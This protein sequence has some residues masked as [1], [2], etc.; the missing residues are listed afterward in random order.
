MGCDRSEHFKF[1]ALGF[2]EGG[3]WT[4]KGMTYLARLPKPSELART[5][6][7]LAS[8]FPGE[9]I[10]FWTE[11]SRAAVKCARGGADILQRGKENQFVAGP[12]N[13][14]S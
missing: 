13:F 3:E 8:W 10:R 14:A 9:L 1:T 7:E 12:I 4:G 5:C 6:I 2:A 11:I